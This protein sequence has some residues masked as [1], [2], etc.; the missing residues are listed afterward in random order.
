MRLQPCDRLADR[1]LAPHFVEDLVSEA[2]VHDEPLVAGARRLYER[3]RGRNVRDLVGARMASPK[4]G[5]ERT[6]PESSRPWPAA[7]SVATRPPML[8]PRRKRR[9]PAMPSCD[10]F[11]TN[12]ARSWR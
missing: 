3:A 5:D 2:V 6:S 10:S 1:L 12:A 11:A 8:W 4:Y 9:S 7:Q